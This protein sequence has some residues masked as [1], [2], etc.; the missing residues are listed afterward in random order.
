VPNVE[1]SDE[2]LKTIQTYIIPVVFYLYNVAI[3]MPFVYLFLE[4]I[5]IINIYFTEAIF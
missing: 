3:S 1:N 2:V 5:D 4:F